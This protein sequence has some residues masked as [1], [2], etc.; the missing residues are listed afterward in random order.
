M[1]E[2]EVLRAL[3]RMESALDADKQWYRK[4][5]ANQAE[6]IRALETK[7][8]ALE[9]AQIQDRVA[10]STLTKRTRVS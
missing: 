1:S 10:A 6:L 2:T 3:R 9:H 5:F 4:K 8:A 7:V